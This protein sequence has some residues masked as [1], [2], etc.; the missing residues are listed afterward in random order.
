MRASAAHRLAHPRPPACCRWR[1]YGVQR[2]LKVVEQPSAGP[3]SR[4]AFIE[5]NGM[6]GGD[7]FGLS[8]NWVAVSEHVSTENHSHP[9]TGPTRFAAISVQR[10]CERLKPFAVTVACSRCPGPPRVAASTI[11]KWVSVVTPSCRRCGWL[12]P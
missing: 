10:P 6:N 3:S 9:L 11:L 12:A 1:G 7:G 8:L 2:L 4:L 5:S